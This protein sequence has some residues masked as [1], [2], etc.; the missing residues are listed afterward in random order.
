MRGFGCPTGVNAV[1]QEP[2]ADRS[3]GRRLDATARALLCGRRGRT[4]AARAQAR[5]C[6]GGRRLPA[7]R[8]R[9]GCLI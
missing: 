5:A 3:D 4:A 2:P 7:A 9:A 1:T 6:A 8:T